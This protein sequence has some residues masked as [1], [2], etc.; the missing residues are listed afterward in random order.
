MTTPH[1]LIAYIGYQK[2]T[3]T[4]YIRWTFVIGNKEHYFW[5]YPYTPMYVSSV[6]SSSARKK[7]NAC[8]FFYRAWESTEYTV[9][10]HNG[11]DGWVEPKLFQIMLF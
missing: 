11:V 1:L 7:M 9:L 3:N 10:T 5:F 2:C 8:D 4:N 6:Y